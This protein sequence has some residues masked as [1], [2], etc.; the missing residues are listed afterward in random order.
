MKEMLP[1]QF[2]TIKMIFIR[3]P[4]I[5]EAKTFFETNLN[6]L[7]F[8]NDEFQIKLE[9]GIA[10]TDARTAY[11]GIYIKKRDSG[12]LREFKKWTIPENIVWN[13]NLPTTIE[14]ILNYCHELDTENSNDLRF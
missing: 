9:E 3:I 5:K 6:R 13:P 1:Q 14:G 7:G 2:E 8:S 10:Q 4:K 12:D 11:I